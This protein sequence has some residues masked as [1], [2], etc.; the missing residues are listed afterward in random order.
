MKNSLN[1]DNLFFN[2]AK[3]AFFSHSSHMHT[4][5]KDLIVSLINEYFE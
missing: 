1:F 4:I 2:N 3:K 5:L